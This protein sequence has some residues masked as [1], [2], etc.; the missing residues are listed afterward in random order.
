MDDPRRSRRHVIAS[1]LRSRDSW[2]AT[3]G[4]STDGHEIRGAAPP[5]DLGAVVALIIP[6]VESVEG[7]PKPELLE[8][9]TEENVHRTMEELAGEALLAPRIA[10]GTLGVAGGEYELGSGLVDL[11]E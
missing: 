7:T 3:S 5:G 2:P 6:A 11:V 8:A 1:T 9:A 4:S 10:D